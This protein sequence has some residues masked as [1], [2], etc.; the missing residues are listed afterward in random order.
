MKV[1]AH[2]DFTGLYL[3]GGGTAAVM[4]TTTKED[5]ISNLNEVLSERGLLADAKIED[6]IE[7]D[8]ENDGAVYILC[9]GEIT[10]E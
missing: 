6:L 9:D 8:T 10:D 4:V 3:E 1:Y 2:K 7:I 5:A